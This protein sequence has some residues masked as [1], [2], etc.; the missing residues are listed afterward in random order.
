MTSTATDE[1][2]ER[3]ALLPLDDR[4]V[5]TQ[6]P[7]DVAAIAGVHVDVPPA[8]LL[9]SFRRPGDPVGL[10]RWLAERAADP[11]IHGVLVS[12]DML[13]YGGLIAGRIS[14]EDLVDVLP[15]LSVLADIRSRRPDLAMTAMSL[16]MRASDSYSATEEPEYWSSFGRDIH[17]LGA[18]VHRRADRIDVAPVASMT[19]V[20]AG[21]VADF[22]HRRLRNHMV[23]LRVVEM[24]T[25][26]V[27]D[28]A[29]VTT[30]DT[31][32]YSYG[33]AEQSWLRHWMRLLPGGDRVLTYPGADEVGAVLVARALA[34]RFGVAVSIEV[35]CPDSNGWERVAPF[36]NVP[37]RD[38][39][40]RQIEA[41]GAVAAPAH[42]DIVLVVHAPDPNRHDQT[43]VEPPPADEIAVQQTFEAI[44]GYLAA[45][46]RVALADVRFANG[47]DP[48]LVRALRAGGLLSRLTAFGGWNTAGNTIGGVV[49]TACVAVVAERSGRLD[50]RALTRALVRRL[51]DDFAFQALVR[52]QG[53]PA[54]SSGGFRQVGSAEA[55]HA[56]A[57]IAAR[58]S[59]V[60][61]AELPFQEW[62]ISHVAL[63]W[64]RG[65]E[66]GIELDGPA[67]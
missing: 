4:P 34:E 10:G 32:P 54:L 16:V 23:N 15:R 63:P 6:L 19:T 33:S 36:E 2:D 13:C 58:L 46:R 62:S 17:R 8:E 25:S 26:G 60:L 20:P 14:D 11:A 38:S 1:S 47:A 3:I 22:A 31:A 5:N 27:I 49:A 50:S 48:A 40:R 51:L 67:R 41:A 29:A 43:A 12:V 66:V 18:D 37:L 7:R 42:A 44:C 39:V 45:G 28:F 53:E 61:N 24:A 30:D 52:R 21:V 64:R 56:E 9:P 55:A 35:V 57:S 59:A 65:F